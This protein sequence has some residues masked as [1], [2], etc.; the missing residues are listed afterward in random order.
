MNSDELK[1]RVNQYVNDLFAPEDEVLNWI[2]AEADRHEMPNI[3][4]EAYEGRLLQF[5]VMITGAKK[6]V[7]IGALAGYSGVWIARGLPKDGK[8]TT[9]DV[10]SKHAQ[11]ARSSFE[12][13]GLAHKVEV[14]QGHALDILRK[15]SPQA[16]YDMVFIDADKPSYSAYLDWATENLRIGGMVMAHN[17]IRGGNIFA[18]DN[19]DDKA[20]AE[21]NQYL[22]NNKRLE[23]TIIAVGDGLAVGVKV[24]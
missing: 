6:V 17:A 15:I 7:E 19:P 1:K 20:M 24:Q 10:S 11:V 3:S 16:P 4:I 13:A 8:L 14:L 21:F 2:Q 22:A 12:K 9:I 5:L 23:S 18:P